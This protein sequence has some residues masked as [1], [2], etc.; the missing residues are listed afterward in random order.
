LCIRNVIAYA[1]TADVLQTHNIQN[2]TADES[3]QLPLPA[4]WM[5]SCASD[6]IK[7]PTVKSASD[8]EDTVEEL[9]LPFHVLLYELSY[10]TLQYTGISCLMSIVIVH[11]HILQVL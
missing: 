9:V 3:N 1:V 2:N 6:D 11:Y 4:Q 10:C 7:L 5:S 8:K